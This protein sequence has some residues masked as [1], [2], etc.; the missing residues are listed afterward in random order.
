MAIVLN[1]LQYALRQ[2]RKAPGFTLVCTLTLALGIGANTAVFS[3]MN[4]VLLKSLPVADPDRVVYL[5]TSG[6]PR[7]T[8]TIDSRETF[9]YPVYDALR[10]QHGGLEQVM[11]SVPLSM[12]K[13]AVRY[14]AQPEEAEGDMVSGNFF[15]GLGVKL[16]RGRGFTE[17][18]ET[19]HAAIA[20]IS[21]NY[22]TR[23][24]SRAPDVLGKTLYVNGVPMTI[25]GIAAESFEG[26]DA[27]NS[28]DFWIPLQNRAE[29]N[30][31]GNPPEDGKTYQEN[32]TWW[33]LHLLGRLAPSAT[34]EQ[35]V[36]QV[37]SAFQTAAYI[38]L[39]NPEPG[40]QRPVLSLQD[41]RNFPGY[42]EIGR[43]SCRER[44]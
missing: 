43:A 26:A 14:E 7:R 10:Q 17:Q 29:L 40:E 36:A 39:G 9:S 6:A 18:D 38:G 3:V 30:A 25:V 20:V 37:Q 8:G 16:A 13:V 1:Y 23:R 27:G 12:D 35:A 22:W 19:T 21:Y 11:A 33:C 42:D 15:S 41:A 5:N 28:T 44:V 32:P 4:A 31:W 34:K 2:L 24:F